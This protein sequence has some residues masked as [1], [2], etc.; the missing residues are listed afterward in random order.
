MDI[1]GQSQTAAHS[2]RGPI[3]TLPPTKLAP[4]TGCRGRGCAWERAELLKKDEV[5]GEAHCRPRAISSIDLNGKQHSLQSVSRGR[6][7]ALPQGQHEH[8]PPT[9]VGE[10]GSYAWKM[11]P[12][13]R[14]RW[15]SRKPYTIGRQGPCYTLASGCQNTGPESGQQGDVTAEVRRKG[16]R[17]LGQQDHWAVRRLG[18][19]PQGSVRWRPGTFS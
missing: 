17:T 2:L 13:K 10:V 3:R 8:V 5:K 14:R 12:R 15:Q 4:D 9:M 19:R 11:P 1:Q 6:G 7:G 18:D 16:G